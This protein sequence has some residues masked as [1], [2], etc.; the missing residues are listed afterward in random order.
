TKHNVTILERKSKAIFSFLINRFIEK[1]ITVSN[2]EKYNLLNLGVKEKKVKTIYNGVDLEQFKFEDKIFN[3]KDE[4]KIGILARL[5]PEKN[6]SLFLKIANLLKGSPNIKFYIAGDG[7]EKESIIKT[8]EEFNI[9]NSVELLGNVGNPDRFLKDIHVLLVTSYREVFPMSVIE[10]MAIGTPIVSID[11]GGINEAIE[12]GINGFL[13]PDYLPDR[14]VE[15]I[16]CL[17]SNEEIRNRFITMSRN[18]V[19][20]E[21]SL[22]KMISSI[23]NEY[24]SI[25]VKE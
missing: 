12:N 23:E 5:S 16:N 25:L 19:E 6:H 22:N 14:F 11:V 4:Y 2:F 8:I 24:S 9:S 21:F 10:S 20:R 7:P 17:L 18:K 1:V 3:S 13:I 15:K